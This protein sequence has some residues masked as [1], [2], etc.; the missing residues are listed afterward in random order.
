M[1]NKREALRWLEQSKRDLQSA[2]KNL[3]EN[4]FEWACFLSLQAGEKS[5]KAV[6]YSVGYRPY[7]HSLLGLLKEIREKLSVNVDKIYVSC[8]ELDKHY[9]ATRYPDVFAEG[10]PGEYYNEKNAR[11]CIKCANIILTF[12]VELMEKMKK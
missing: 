5:L 8:Q 4:I 11:S 9:I 7:G 12:A 10:I 3:K 1:G 2:E 6:L